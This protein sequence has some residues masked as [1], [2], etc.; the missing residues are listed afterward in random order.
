MVRRRSLGQDGGNARAGGRRTLPAGGK[1]MDLREMAA[2]W[3]AIVLGMALLVAGWW[4]QAERRAGS[5]GAQGAAAAAPGSDAATPDVR[6]VVV[7]PGD[8]L[9]GLAQRFGPAGSDT[10]ELVDT[11]IQLNG[12]DTRKPLTPGRAL[13]IPRSW[14]PLRPQ[15][16]P[17]LSTAGA[18]AAP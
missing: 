13:R 3:A 7:E 4:T 8:T 12:L 11:L 6:W 18:A 17:W 14:T 15:H 2:C 10:R 1:P 16:R 5:M 9:W